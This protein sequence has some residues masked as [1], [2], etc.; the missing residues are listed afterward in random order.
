M[1]VPFMEMIDG[2]ISSLQ[3]FL[4]G[5]LPEGMLT[6]FAVEGVLTGVGAFLVFVPQIILLFVG[7]GILEQTGFLSRAAVIVDKPLALLG[8]SGRSFLLG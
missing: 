6:T 8:L 2:G 5:A 7:L 1:A 4:L 3:K